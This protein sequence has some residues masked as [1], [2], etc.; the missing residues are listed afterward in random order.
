MKTIQEK[1]AKLI[2]EKGINLQKD[3]NLLIKCEY[4]HYEFARIIA[5][6]AYNMGAKHVHFNL[7]DL[8]LERCK[9]DNQKIEEYKELPAFFNNMY[10]TFEKNKW[11]YLVID[12][13]EG[14]EFLKGAK[15]DKIVAK[16]KKLRKISKSFH[17]ALNNND[18]PWCVVGVPGPNWAKK[19]LGEARTTEDMW[20]LIAPILKLDKPNPCIEWE[21]ETHNFHNRMEYLNSLGIKSLHYTSDI[22][23]FTV[24]FHEDSYWVGGPSQLPNGNTFYANLPTYEIFN[25]P[26]ITKCSGFFTTTKPVTVLGEETEEVKFI[27]KNGKID[28]F[29]AKKGEKAIKKLLD[30]DT[31]SRQLGE[32]A[33]V[34]ESNPIAKSGKIFSSILY[35]EN[36]SCHIAIGSCYPECFKNLGKES[37]TTKNGNKS[38]VHVD[39]MIGSKSLKIEATCIDGSVVTIM[40]NGNYAF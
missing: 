29:T 3:Q 11:A 6:L 4:Q 10:S 17:A 26:D 16:N 28:S 40:E 21:K 32:I 23:N 8:E 7:V 35:D 13:T 39:F 38:D 30:T 5:L 20:K 34:D 25:S 36:A 15:I 19:V 33:L 18:I 31:G 14:K 2:L 12:S 37:V 27:L 1:Y 24:G 9:L 22:T